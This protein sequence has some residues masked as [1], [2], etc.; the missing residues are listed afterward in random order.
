M[1]KDYKNQLEFV[2]YGVKNSIFDGINEYSSIARALSLNDLLKE[3]VSNDD[4]ELEKTI[5]VTNKMIVWIEIL[6]SKPWKSIASIIQNNWY[7]LYTL[8]YFV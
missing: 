4:I 2:R 1:Y 6:Q 7:K 8:F 3:N 5:K